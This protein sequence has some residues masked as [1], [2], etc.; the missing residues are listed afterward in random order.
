[1][2]YATFIGYIVYLTP[3]LHILNKCPPLCSFLIDLPE[4]G[5][6]GGT[7]W[8]D[9]WLFTVDCAVVGLNAV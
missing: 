6:V 5:H 8:G 2:F 7:W 1:M 9:K 4:D 3:H